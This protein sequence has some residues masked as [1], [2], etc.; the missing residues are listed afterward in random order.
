MSKYDAW[1]KWFAW[2]PVLVGGKWAW[3]RTIERQLYCVYDPRFEY[4]NPPARV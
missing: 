2:Y 4:R 3:F 1:H